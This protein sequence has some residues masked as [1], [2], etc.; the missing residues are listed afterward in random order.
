MSGR[1]QWQIAAILKD[2]LAFSSAEREKLTEDPLALSTTER[3]KLTEENVL[4]LND[5]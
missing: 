2:L 1:L 3:E 4:A 5:I